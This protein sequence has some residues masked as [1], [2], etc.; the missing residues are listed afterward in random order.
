VST[1]AAGQPP[2]ECAAVAQENLPG[3]PDRAVV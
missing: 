3:I 2:R 1:S